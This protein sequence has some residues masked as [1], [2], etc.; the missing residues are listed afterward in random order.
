[1]SEQHAVSVYEQAFEVYYESM[2][3]HENAKQRLSFD[4]WKTIFDDCVVPAIK[5]V[6]KLDREG[7]QSSLAGVVERQAEYIEES[8]RLQNHW[9]SVDERLPDPKGEIV[10]AWTPY[11]NVFPAVVYYR[12]DG[13]QTGKTVTHWQ[14]I[15]TPEDE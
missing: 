2:S 9:I 8:R 6:R 11:A 1:M 10:L 12:D 14:P 5:L 15:T 13:F 3:D 7:K 4:D